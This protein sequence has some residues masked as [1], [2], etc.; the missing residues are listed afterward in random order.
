MATSEKFVIPK[1][2][3]HYDHWSMLMENFLRSLEMWNL[4]E[5]GVPSPAIGTSPA[6]EAQRKRVAEAKLT[7]LK[8]KNFLFQA[9]EREIIETILDKMTSKAIWDSMRQKYQGSTKVKRAQLQAL[10]KEFEMLNMKEGEKVDSFLGRTLTV[11]NKMKMNGEAVQPSTVVS[12]ILRSL[13]SKFNHV[14]CAIEE[15][16]D[17][18]TMS[19]DEL[20]GSLLVQ[21]QRMQESQI[22]EQVLKVS[23]DGQPGRGRGRSSY[24]GGQGG[25]GGQGKGRGRTFQDKATIECFKCHQLGHYQYECPG[26]EKK[27]NYVQQGEEEELLL[28]DFVEPLQ[29]KR[30]EVWFLDSGCSNHMTGNK[31]WFTELEEGF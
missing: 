6:S 14:V 15:S 2:D 30:E 12:K 29:T 13:T 17:I 3:G 27:A 24:R 8:V 20:H 25:R 26:W 18:D 16:N 10:R 22:E 23:S 31:E 5:E 11:V 28:M 4:V 1:F 9:I 21:E 7:D 19:I